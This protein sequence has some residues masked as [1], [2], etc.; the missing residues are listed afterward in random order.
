[1]AKRLDIF[2][3]DLSVDQIREIAHRATH[4]NA[5]A[6][7]KA[8]EIIARSR[9]ALKRADEILSRASSPR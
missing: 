2:P 1:M 8:H 6:L 5:A 4:E 9:E 7:A 3:A